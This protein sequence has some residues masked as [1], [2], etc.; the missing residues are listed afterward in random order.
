MESIARKMK[1]YKKIEIVMLLLILVSLLAL[2]TGCVKGNLF[3]IINYH[4]EDSGKYSTGQAELTDT[5]EN[6]E[7]DWISG[8]VMVIATDSSAV[9]FAEESESELTEAMQ[10]RYWLDGT[11]LRIKFCS[12]GKWDFT[13]IKKELTVSLP[14]TLSFAQI[15]VNSVSANVNLKDVC[16]ETAE[17]NTVSG[18]VIFSDCSVTNSAKVN[19]VSGATD[20]TFKQP[21]KEFHGNST[22]GAFSVSA[23]FISRFDVDT[24]SGVVRLSAQNEPEWLNVETVS[25]DVNLVLPENASFT[26]DF[27]SSSGDL[28]SVLTYRQAS[29]KYVFGDGKGEYKIDTVSGDVHITK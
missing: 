25:G 24:V 7:I 23:P 9:S 29:G 16:A 4:Y 13:D 17:I 5:I 19:T 21:L 12:C 8:D 11:T 3:G 26:L 2:L 14:N 10:L 22:S 20:A 6:I 18:A 27:D 1:A 28:Y 15:K